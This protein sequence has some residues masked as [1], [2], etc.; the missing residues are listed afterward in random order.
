M[1]APQTP[2]KK[3]LPKNR[4]LEILEQIERIGLPNSDNIAT[5]KKLIGD[6][7]AL[8]SHFSSSELI[9]IKQLD[10]VIHK[11]DARL[12]EDGDIPIKM[13]TNLSKPLIVLKA[14]LRGLV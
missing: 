6:L 8:A 11:I 14:A 4:A 9:I 12:K 5:L 13:Y 2:N 7:V 3:L 1:A 10:K